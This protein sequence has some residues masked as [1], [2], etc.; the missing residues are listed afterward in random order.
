MNVFSSLFTNP[1]LITLLRIVLNGAPLLNEWG[2]ICNSNISLGSVTIGCCMLLRWVVNVIVDRS[3]NNILVVGC[4]KGTPHLNI[5][6]IVTTQI[7]M[8]I[9]ENLFVW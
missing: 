1:I 5:N 4:M 8:S 3:D 7:L 6:K 2:I 9:H